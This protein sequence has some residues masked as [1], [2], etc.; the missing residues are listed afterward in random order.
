MAGQAG[1]GRSKSPSPYDRKV[2]RCGAPPGWLFGQ[3]VWYVLFLSEIVSQ[4]FTKT[5]FLLIGNAAR[6]LDSSEPRFALQRERR[7]I[8]S[9]KSIANSISRKKAV[10]C[11]D[12]A[13]RRRARPPTV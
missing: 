5:P 7:W 12:R 3:P 11:S 6:E 1:R 2:A 9:G 4:S 10:L 13:F 8:A